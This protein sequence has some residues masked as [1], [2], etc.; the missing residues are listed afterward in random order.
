MTATDYVSTIQ[1]LDQAL[2]DARIAT[3]S[4]SSYL[5]AAYWLDNSKHNKYR[6]RVMIEEAIKEL[7][8]AIKAMDRIPEDM[9]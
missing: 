7:H 8:K 6:R 9:T 5:S 2:I 3:D 4:A 1:V